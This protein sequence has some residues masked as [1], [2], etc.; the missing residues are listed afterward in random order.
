[1]RQV[2]GER[3]D[4]RIRCTLSASPK[5]IKGLVAKNSGPGIIESTIEEIEVYCIDSNYSWMAPITN[6]LQDEK[7]P[8]YQLEA[9]K[10]RREVAKYPNRLYRREFLNS[11]LRCLDLN[12]AKYAMVE[13]HEG[14]CGTHIGGRSLASKIARVDYY[15]PTLKKDCLEFVKKCDRC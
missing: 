8:T 6:Y 5:A 9:K 14:I 7:V 13:V 11:L 15:W 10:I 2:V 1:M 4:G 12:E 3:P